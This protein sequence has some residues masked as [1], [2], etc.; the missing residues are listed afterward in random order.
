MFALS[1]I[2]LLPCIA[3]SNGCG[4]GGVGDN[5]DD[6]RIIQNPVFN[7]D[8]SPPVAW[9]YPENNA[10]AS[11]SYLPGQRLSQADANIQ[12]NA[13]LEAAVLSALVESGIP[14]QG[15][16]V[17]STYTAPEISDCK[18]VGSVITM[19]G[20]RVGIV[21]SGAVVKILTP[22]A[23]SGIPVADCMSRAF[24]TSTTILSTKEDYSIQSTVQVDGF[25]GT[26][27]QM[28]Q[29]SRQL[30]AILNFKYNARFISEIQVQ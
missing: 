14:T 4:A 27:F 9:T 2:F 26:K 24:I 28:R 10:E 29:I 11:G 23:S 20:Q 3:L 21:E 8:F 17:R 5:A 15:V 18:K 7:L 1:L 22:T 25:T 12:A 19:L 6:N 13:D 16:T 30:M